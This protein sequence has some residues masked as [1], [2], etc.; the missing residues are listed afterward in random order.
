ML[1]YPHLEDHMNTIGIEQSLYNRFSFEHKWLN[2]IQNIYQ[3][4]CKCDYQQNL[5]DIIDASM[6]STQEKVTDDS[7]S[8]PMT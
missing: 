1:Q 2:N 5:K 6:V 3:H 7:T 4:E 8:L